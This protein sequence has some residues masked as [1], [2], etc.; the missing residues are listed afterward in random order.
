MLFRSS[1]VYLLAHTTQQRLIAG[2]L[3][4]GIARTGLSAE[5]SEDTVSDARHR[6][7]EYG[8]TDGDTVTEADWGDGRGVGHG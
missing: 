7:E 1:Q 2:E 6:R 3:G 8:D 4:G 5:A